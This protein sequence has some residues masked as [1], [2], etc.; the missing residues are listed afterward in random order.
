MKEESLD[1]LTQPTPEQVEAWVKQYGRL[2]KAT[3]KDAE[4]DK[5]GEEMVFYFKKI[6]LDAL[7]L[8]NQALTQDK[9][10][11]KYAEIILA[12]SI[13]NGLNYL[14]DADVFIALLP[15]ADQLLT[16]KIATLEKN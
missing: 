11:I 2:K 3:I 8:A 16:N 13:V 6:S 5:A 10:N 1:N 15:I 7:R 12:N 4:G 14:K 9:D